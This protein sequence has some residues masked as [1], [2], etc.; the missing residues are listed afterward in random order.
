MSIQSAIGA[1][2]HLKI[3]SKAFMHATDVLMKND[4]PAID[5]QII[6]MVAA[7]IGAIVLD[8]CKQRITE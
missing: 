1:E 4:L 2:E 5:K 6:L 3:I 8:Y 7:S